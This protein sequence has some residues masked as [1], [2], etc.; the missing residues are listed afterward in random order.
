MR[1]LISRHSRLTWGIMLFALV[2]AVFLATA[3]G[4][5]PIPPARILA[6]LGRGLG[7]TSFAGDLPP[8]EVAIVMDVRLPRV[9][10]AAVVGAGL[11]LAGTVF[12][13]LLRNPL[14]D[15]YVIGTA[16]GAALGATLALLAS[17]GLAAWG[18]IPVPVAAFLGALA[19]VSIVYR[20][21]II[22]SRTPIITLLLAGFAVS[23][24]LTASMA[25]LWLLNDVTLKRTIYWTMGGFS[26]SGWKELTVV[27]PLLLGA[28]VASR[29]FTADL[30]ALLLGEEAAAHLGVEVERRKLALLAIGSL[31]TAAAV[32]IS[33]LI[34]FVGLIV[35]HIARLL[36]GP[37]HRT[38]LPAAAVAGAI[39]LVLADLIA[40]TLLAPQEIPVG[41]ITA[42][43]GAP[44]FIW[45]LR[46]H[47]REYTF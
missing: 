12:Q 42:L 36:F 2:G 18:F 7:V 8:R 27:I 19:A 24:V 29:L 44:F 6:I 22:G 3:G 26:A 35:P 46:R 31:L 39:F 43:L 11:A 30:N 45:L 21:S 37:D 15:P 4:A 38:L 14:A 23:S 28:G 10:T 32:S 47:K 41:I 20:V 34:G 5:V 1:R 16:A 40:R 25:F 17:A 33:G 9:V 13:G